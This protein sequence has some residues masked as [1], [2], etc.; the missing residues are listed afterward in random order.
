MSQA[1][2]VPRIWTQRY[3]SSSSSSS[4]PAMATAAALVWRVSLFSQQSPL[5][6]YPTYPPPFAVAVLFAVHDVVFVIVF[7]FVIVQATPLVIL[8]YFCGEATTKEKDSIPLPTN[9]KHP[10]HLLLLLLRSV[11]A[12][13]IRD[14]RTRRRRG[15]RTVTTT[16]G[17]GIQRQRLGGGVGWVVTQR[18]YCTT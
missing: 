11:Q 14:G 5:G 10:P 7:V 4:Y 13:V 6:D 2:S 8:D 16:K 18:R 17:L 1:F 12:N 15:R 3:Y 9:L